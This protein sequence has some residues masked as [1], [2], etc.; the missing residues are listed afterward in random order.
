MLIIA[1]GTQQAYG[2]RHRTVGTQVDIVPT[3]VSLLGESFKHQCW[4]RDLLSLKDDDSGFSFI[5]PSGSNQTVA[6]IKGNNILIKRPHE[7]TI[8]GL[9]GFYPKETYQILND[10]TL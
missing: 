4:G 9:Y 1:P 6:F 5:K 10:K 2:R 7:K 3:L 8:L